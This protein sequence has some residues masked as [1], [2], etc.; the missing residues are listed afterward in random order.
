MSRGG[1]YKS[2][3]A[4]DG[5]EL[6]TVDYSSGVIMCRSLETSGVR[7]QVPC[8]CYRERIVALIYLGEIEGVV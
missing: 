6:G 7:R 4:V 8:Q 1:S 2:D 3:P 5:H